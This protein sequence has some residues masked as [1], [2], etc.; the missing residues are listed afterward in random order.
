MKKIFL[1][2]CLL[3][4]FLAGCG[5]NVQG[6]IYFQSNRFPLKDKDYSSKDGISVYRSGVVKNLYQGYGSPAVTEN[7]DKLIAYIGNETGK[8]VVFDIAEGLSDFI[9]I[10]ITAL[11]F[12][13]FP[14][15]KRVAMT[16]H[17]INKGYKEQ[18]YNIYILNIETG[19]IKKITDYSGNKR[20]VMY[21]ISISKDGKKIAYTYSAEKGFEVKVVDVETRKLEALPFNAGNVEWSDTDNILALS[22]KPN[23][24]E[25]TR[26]TVIIYDYETKKYKKIPREDNY[27][28]VSEMSFSPDGKKLAYIRDENDGRKTLWTMNVDGTKRRQLIDGHYLIKSINWTE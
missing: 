22:G 20:F 8:L 16:G 25:G 6:K 12:S 10:P 19:D 1:V 4:V 7:G 15:N 14:D 18:I 28:W 11:R 5:S 3:A 26:S 13:W 27:Q 21:D 9:E 24:E 2:V 17:E 23:H